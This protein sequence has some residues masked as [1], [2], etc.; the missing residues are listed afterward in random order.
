MKNKK[1]VNNLKSPI[2]DIE[3]LSKLYLKKK[4]NCTIAFYN[5]K[6]I[7][8]ILT[9][10]Q[11]KY[12]GIF[13]EYLIYEDYTEFLKKQY[14]KKEI[15]KSFPKI[16]NFYKK[17][18]KIYPNYIPLIESKYLY[19]NIKR[20]QK[21]IYQLQEIKEEKKLK[22]YST[23]ITS[24]ALNSINENTISNKLTTSKEEEDINKIINDINFY[25]ELINKKND[26]NLNQNLYPNKNISRQKL[27]NSALLSPTAQS[28]LF[29]K[30]KVIQKI[31]KK[32]L[33]IYENEK[34]IN[35]KIILNNFYSNKINSPQL[36]NKSNFNSSEEKLILSKRNSFNLIKNNSNNNSINNIKEKIGL[37]INNESFRNKLFLNKLDNLKHLSGKIISFKENE[38][39]SK[40][41]SKT[42]DT[43][44]INNNFPNNQ[45]QI[46]FLDKDSI[47]SN[48]QK[49]IFIL[50]FNNV[51]SKTTK[52]SPLRKISKINNL[53][54]TFKQIS[55][56]KNLI[57]KNINDSKI[58][59]SER[60]SVSKN[61][62]EKS[63]IS[64]KNKTIFNKFQKQENKLMSKVIKKYPSYKRFVRKE[65]SDVFN[66]KHIKYNNNQI[67][68][69]EFQIKNIIRRKNKSTN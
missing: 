5:L 55:D 6:K 44:S 26:K 13:K 9:N 42:K 59:L 21:I 52:N 30:K 23:I 22:T 8:E 61:F 29:E 27:I 36:L 1:Q 53:N 34:Q 20:K 7:N 28:K 60:N 35:E 66:C 46:N 38:K 49:S 31:L 4:Y 50:K 18:C 54:N 17:Y 69:K 64:L 57:K 43:S 41:T 56:F 2:K 24:Q 67:N 11:C 58:P 47:K 19:R 15:K 68:F 33:G 39:K 3:I 10:K 65:N 45:S 16:L 62:F 51:N 48:I 12:V 37:N 14:N 63:S 25:E 40:S 32:N